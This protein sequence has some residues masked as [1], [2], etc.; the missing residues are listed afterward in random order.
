ML[1]TD[2]IGKE[3]VKVPCIYYLFQFYE[4]QKLE[5]EGQKQEQKSQK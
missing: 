4:G 5:Q 1:V 3:V 2:T